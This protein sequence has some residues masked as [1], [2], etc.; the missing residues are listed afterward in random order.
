MNT[1]Y[2]GL[3]GMMLIGAVVAFQSPQVREFAQERLGKT[4]TITEELPLPVQV[5]NEKLAGAWKAVDGSEVLFL[6]QDGKCRNAVAF[7]FRNDNADSVLEGAGILAVFQGNYVIEGDT[8]KGAGLETKSYRAN[9]IKFDL[10]NVYK[11]DTVSSRANLQT[12]AQ[13]DIPPFVRQ[14]YDSWVKEDQ[15]GGQVTKLTAD[16]LNI[17]RAD[18]TIVRYDRIDPNQAR[19]PALPS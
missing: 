12:T 18:G 19:D 16:T 13:K 6:R 1:F 9:G 14:I 2:L 10:E 11:F 15:V 7:Q 17:R 4:G 5:T 8:I 3:T